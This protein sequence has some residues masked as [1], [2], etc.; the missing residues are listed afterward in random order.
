M[1]AEAAVW[2][3]SFGWLEGGMKVKVH[4]WKPV[5]LLGGMS[6]WKSVDR[7]VLLLHHNYPATCSKEINAS[8]RF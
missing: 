4:D 8:A 5:C 6:A 3:R 7:H 1:E 2:L